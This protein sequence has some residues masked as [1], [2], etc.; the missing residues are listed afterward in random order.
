MKK[1]AWN[2]L[3]AGLLVLTAQNSNAQTAVLSEMYGRGVHAYYAGTMDQSLQYFTMAIDN[4]IQDPRAYY[5]RGMV[6]EMTGR[7]EE[8][9]ADW[10]AGA[11]MEAAGRTNPM[12]GKSLSR[13]QGTPRLKLETIRQKAKLE[14]LAMAMKRSK[15]RYGELGA[16]NQAATKPIAPVP[17]GTA[18]V[19]P[20]PP[21]GAANPFA[22]DM[23]QGQPRVVA[24]D[25]FKDALKDPFA[26]EAA[27]AG[28]A[29]STPPAG[30]PFGGNGAGGG[31]DPFGGAGAGGGA[32]PFGGA[33]AGG[34]ADPFGGA[35]GGGGADPFGGGTS[36]GGAGAGG[37]DPFGGAGAGGADPFGGAGSDPFG[38]K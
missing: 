27:T 30:N 13:L 24:D 20:V 18:R 37:A 19:A 21:T 32:D 16:A 9:E 29:G 3:A 5:F 35:G 4:S 8:A 7:P 36:G 26:G 15:E 23:A 14:A 34:G 17:P 2:L 6:Y 12:I 28:A 1:I 38:S 33:G 25:A 11:K 10:K 31:A 22:D